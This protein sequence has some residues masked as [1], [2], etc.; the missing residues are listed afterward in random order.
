MTP[1]EQALKLIEGRFE[2]IEKLSLECI[3]MIYKAAYNEAIEDALNL[4]DRSD[5]DAVTALKKE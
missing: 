2:T 3:E 4:K 1:K 5:V